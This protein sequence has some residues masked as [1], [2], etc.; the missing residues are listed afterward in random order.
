M[1]SLTWGPPAELTLTPDVVSEILE[2]ANGVAEGDSCLVSGSIIEG[3]GN[4][5]SDIDL[6]VVKASQAIDE[7]IAIGMRET[8]YVDCEY[9]QLES[10]SQLMVK[11]GSGDWESAFRLSRVDLDRYYR[12]SIALPV[13]VAPAA[14]DLLNQFDAST[15]RS[16][17]EKWALLL[18][19]SLLGRSAVMLTTGHVDAARLLAREA[20]LWTAVSELALQ[21][22]GYVSA[23]W[24]AEKAA[25][26]YGR[27]SVDYS[28]LL[29]DYLRPGD[30]TSALIARVRTRINLPS[31]ALELLNTRTC[32]LAE[33][34]S[35]VEGEGS[36]YLILPPRRVAEVAG[37]VA[38]FCKL[39]ADGD[40]WSQ[41]ALALAAELKIASSD[42]AS[43]AWDVTDAL[44]A[45]NFLVR[46][47]GD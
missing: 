5:N 44:R 33:G 6:Y 20:A 37:F 11:V 29:D 30:D 35:F 19:Q 24:T 2:V 47:Q 28:R 16:A 38:L 42:V 22:E 39:L 1:S 21:G 34:V 13:R 18:A 31:E 8:R 15:A 25:R 4:K 43:A 46:V 17:L 3:F 40:S 32:R 9:L 12:L 45:L 26:R 27:N 7:S 10:L 23:K 41:A 14:A 36:S